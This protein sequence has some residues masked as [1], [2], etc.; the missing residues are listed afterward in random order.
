M[1][2]INIFSILFVFLL[3]L[4]SQA[5]FPACMD[6]QERLELNMSQILNYRDQLENK[7]TARAYIKGIIVGV[8]ENRQNHTHF[9]VDLDNNLESIDD[10]IE[11]IYSTKFGELPSYKTGDEIIA[12]GDFIIDQYSPLKAVVHWLHLSPPGNK[13][14]HGFLIINGIVAG[15][16]LKENIK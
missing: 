16:T 7:F 4:R 9:E 11:V 6:K 12:C 15:Q 3:S 10:R 5:G 1:N 13:H 8:I 2:L 14:E